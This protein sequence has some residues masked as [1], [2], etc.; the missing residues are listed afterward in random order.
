LQLQTRSSADKR[1][2]R[3]KLHSQNRDKKKESR[4]QS[5]AQLVAWQ[6][7][8][9]TARKAGVWQGGSPRQTTEQAPPTHARR[10]RRPR[11]HRKC[12]K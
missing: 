2:R 12:S 5:G 11:Q 1:K 7:A 3:R 4:K 9:A 10:P 8:E 6:D